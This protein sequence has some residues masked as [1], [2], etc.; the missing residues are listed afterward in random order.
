MHR[1]ETPIL[2]QLCFV[3]LALALALTLVLTLALD[4]GW[5]YV[6]G[7]PRPGSRRDGRR[8]VSV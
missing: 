6:S 5:R 2:Y 7:L 1:G 4:L 3:P 8:Y